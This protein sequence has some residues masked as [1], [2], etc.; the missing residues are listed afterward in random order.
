L[1]ILDKGHLSNAQAA[2]LLTDPAFRPPSQV[3]WLAHLSQNNNTPRLAL[4]TAKAAI[5][6]VGPVIHVVGPDKPS[7]PA[8]FT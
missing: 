2:A 6:E 3:L 4:K 1:E 5:G 7:H 8:V